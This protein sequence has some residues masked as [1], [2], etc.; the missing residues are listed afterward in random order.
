VLHDV[1]Q[2]GLEANH[3]PEHPAIQVSTGY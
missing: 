3:C 2:W 1:L